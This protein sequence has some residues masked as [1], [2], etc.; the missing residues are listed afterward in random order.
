MYR[1]SGGFLSFREKILRGVVDNSAYPSVSVEIE[2]MVA[3]PLNAGEAVP[4]V[5][6]LG[7]IR[8]PF[9]P[10]PVQPIGLGSPHEPTWKEQL[11]S[12]GWG[13]AVVVPASIQPDNGAG[14]TTGIIGLA[15]KGKRRKP[16]DWGA[17]RAW[18]WGAS[19][20]VDYFEKD[21]D[22]DASRIAIEGLSRYGKAAVVA[23]AFD[24]RFSLGFIGSSGAGGMKILRRNFG[25]QVENL[26]ST[27]AY[28]WFCGHFIKY[29]SMLTA[30][31]LPVDAHELAALCAP[32]PIFISAG[33]PQ[34]EGQW[35]D[36]K[37]MFLAGVYAGPVYR[38]L[39]KKDLGAN[40]FPILGAALTG[41]EIAFR[42]HA[43]GHSTGPN[44]STW[45]AWACRYW[46]DCR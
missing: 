19:R 3:T 25:E 32:R 1:L 26:A 18:A 42:Q 5:L 9:N 39:G 45:I 6:E 15:N 13:Y 33:S 40:E 41:G 24:S 27:Y 11:I 38:L 7:F 21:E 2:L 22:V 31:D 28:H 46:G 12:R 29:G 44:W 14:L 36:A 20:A 43:G 35:I 8:S 34:V 30:D 10:G 16:A 4:A 37:G 17:L 23:M